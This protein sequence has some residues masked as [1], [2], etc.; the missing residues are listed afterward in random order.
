M[1]IQASPTS[2]ATTRLTVTHGWRIW[3]SD[4][5]GLQKRKE[6]VRYRIQASE[7]DNNIRWFQRAHHNVVLKVGYRL[8]RSLVICWLRQRTSAEKYTGR[9]QNKPRMWTKQTPCVWEEKHLSVRLCG[10]T[11][12]GQSDRV[13]GD[14]PPQRHRAFGQINSFFCKKTNKTKHTINKEMIAI[15]HMF[16]VL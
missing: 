14:E 12:R 9:D 6:S 8:I 1:K 7:S 16:K 10:L 15:I 11:E 13:Q 2:R 5:G 4:P 3:C